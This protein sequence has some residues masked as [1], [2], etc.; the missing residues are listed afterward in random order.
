MNLHQL[1]RPTAVGLLLFASVE[2]VP[3]FADTFVDLRTMV[4][5]DSMPSG[6]YPGCSAA[7]TGTSS[8]E[9]SFT[10]TLTV[11]SS[12]IPDAFEP[13]TFLGDVAFD[14]GL[15]PYGIGVGVVIRSSGVNYNRSYQ[16]YSRGYGTWSQGAVVV[17]ATGAGFVDVSLESGRLHEA[18]VRLSLWNM[19][20]VTNDF[21]ITVWENPWE[22]GHYTSLPIRIPVTFGVPYMLSGA[23]NVAVCGTYDGLC[24]ADKSP[25]LAYVS[26]LKFFDADGNPLPNA[27]VVV[28]DSIP[29]LTMANPTPGPNGSGWN[30]TSVTINLNA[31]DN[32]G[33]SGVKQIELALGG[34]Q[35]TGWQV[36]PGNTSVTISAE[37]TTVLSYGA[38]DYAGNRE[39][40][41]TLSV[42]IDN[43]PP[44]IS[45]MP[46]PGC[47]L[48]R[49]NGRM[50]QVATIK[51]ADA[52][53][54]LTPGSFKVTG[55]SN[56]PSDPSNP[57]IVITP[58]GS[59]GYV[60]QLRADRLA[61]GTGRTYTLNAT[62]GDLAGNIATATATCTV[63]HDQGSN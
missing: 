38:T 4:I 1:L 62:A 49:P 31:T 18:W 42:N 33:G 39:T 2:L 36:R 41:K 29:P 43:T 61:T 48:W 53:S 63:P 54:G 26:D 32:P 7:Y 22:D 51:A 27:K 30:T 17:G 19:E 60:V 12:T 20:V 55:T 34:A 47:V 45:G 44:V 57:D 58:N 25:G 40:T 24:G 5:S 52:L 13:K 46:A 8:V 59:G 9:A 21:G 15:G 56:E 6:G 14:T 3:A 50:V 37:G 10:C 28:G 16:V 35:N 23:T 11:P